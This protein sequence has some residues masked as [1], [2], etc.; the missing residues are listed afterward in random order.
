MQKGNR[1][2]QEASNVFDRN[3]DSN[4]Q[5]EGGLGKLQ[6][7]AEVER[8]A[9]EEEFWIG[10]ISTIVGKKILGGQESDVFVSKDNKD[11]I[12]LNRFSFIGNDIIGI[13]IFIERL[14]T[15]NELFPQDKYEVVGFSK[16]FEGNI[17]IVLNQSYVNGEEATQEEIDEFFIE[18][19]AEKKRQGIYTLGDYEINDALPNNVIKGKDG[20]LHFIDA[21]CVNKSRKKAIKDY[22]SLVKSLFLPT[23]TIIFF[24]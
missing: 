11:V 9:K 4:Q 8:I 6:F 16:D 10:D 22:Y 13:E 23:V 3:R 21:F 12:K 1:I 20:G 18:K 7:L 17:C 24:S 14:N 2:L 5:E 19:G 15:H